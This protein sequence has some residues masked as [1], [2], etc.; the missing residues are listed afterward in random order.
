MCIH[1][2]ASHTQET[3]VVPHLFLL[4][5]QSYFLNGL[6]KWH[7]MCYHFESFTDFT[8]HHISRVTF[9]PLTLL[10]VFSSYS[11]VIRS[12]VRVAYT[13]PPTKSALRSF[14]FFHVRPDLVPPATRPY[15][16]TV[17]FCNRV[18]SRVYPL[19][20]PLPWTRPSPALPSVCEAS[21]SF[22]I[23]VF[24]FHN[25]DTLYLPPPWL[26]PRFLR[27]HQYTIHVGL[28]FPEGGRCHY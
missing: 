26:N 22:K 24:V 17:L 28:P 11:T 14:D 12:S 18:S 5:P 7:M 16:Y 25:I 3:L 21:I 8:V 15:G 1:L 23:E 9:F 13:P 2:W 20:F 27:Y 4:L 6:T 10:Q 19:H